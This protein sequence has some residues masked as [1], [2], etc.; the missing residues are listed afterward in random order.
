MP[1]VRRQVAAGKATDAESAV[2]RFSFRAMLFWALLGVIV[3][4]LY[5]LL[6]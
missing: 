3:Y 5:L 4:F 1:G 2:G 6:G